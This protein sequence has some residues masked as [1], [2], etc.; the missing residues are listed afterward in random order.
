[1]KNAELQ[2]CVRSYHSFKSL[3]IDGLV[4]LL[5]TFVNT[6]GKYGRFDVKHA[7][8]LNSKSSKKQNRSPLTWI[9]GLPTLII[10]LILMPT[11]FG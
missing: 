5:Q 1:M 10:S 4:T 7:L 3:K 2:F 9:C 6:A 11:R 8:R